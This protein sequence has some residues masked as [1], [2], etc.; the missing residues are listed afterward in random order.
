ML[1]MQTLPRLSLSCESVILVSLIG[2]SACSR[3]STATPDASVPPAA[4]SSVATSA[5]GSA[6]TINAPLL[7]SKVDVSGKIGSTPMKLEYGRASWSNSGYGENAV[8]LPAIEIVL[9]AT[10]LACGSSDKIEPRLTFYLP[11]GPSAHF[12][13]GGTIGLEAEVILASGAKTFGVDV[14]SIR[15]SGA[16]PVENGTISGDINLKKMNNNTKLKGKYF[17]ENDYGALSGQFSLQLCPGAPEPHPTG[18][19]ETQ[20]PDASKP[21]WVMYSDRGDLLFFFGPH[22]CGRSNESTF[23]EVSNLALPRKDLLGPQPGVLRVHPPVPESEVSGGSAFPEG[24]ASIVWTGKGPGNSLTGRIMTVDGPHG[25]F[26]AYTV[27]R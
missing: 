10:P 7:L 18:I 1:V 26:T 24:E 11:P 27:C 25:D 6:S 4:D 12:Y 23:Y 9:T 22:R 15:I 21:T 20:P 3:P 19:P 14:V 8:R 17:D 2:F 5:I 13:A 16:N